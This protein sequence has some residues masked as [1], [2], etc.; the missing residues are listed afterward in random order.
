M[1]YFS[2]VGQTVGME[3]LSSALIE[4]LRVGAIAGGLVVGALIFTSMLTYITLDLF[5]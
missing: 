5:E 4:L 3:L 2:R 1:F